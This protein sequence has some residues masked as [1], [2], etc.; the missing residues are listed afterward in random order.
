MENVMAI[1]LGFAPQLADDIVLLACEMSIGE[2]PIIV[3]LPPGDVLRLGPR[4]IQEGAAAVSLAP[5]RG[6]VFSAGENVGGRLFGPA[7]LP[8]TMEIVASASRA[9]IPTIA[10]GGIYSKEDADAMLAIGAIA[11]QLDSRFWLPDNKKR[12]SS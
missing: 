4:A 5:P 7:L 6:S 2:L 12:A 1:E 8:V 11:V 10:A 3:C 9:G